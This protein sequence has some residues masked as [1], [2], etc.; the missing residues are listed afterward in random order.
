M[1][2]DVT[3]ESVHEVLEEV[4]KVRETG[5][6]ME[7]LDRE[8]RGRLAGLPYL[9]ETAGLTL[10][11][12]EIL[13]GF[14]IPPTYFDTYA[15]NFSA[16]TLA[17][18]QQAAVTYLAPGTLQIL[19]VGDAPVSLTK[20]QALAAMRPDLMASPVIQLDGEGNPVP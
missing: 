13:D 17:D 1:R 12:Y 4:R 2:A 19:V 16:V 3:A 15:R 10:T 14:G 9:F 18:A 11:Q 6:T 5:V 20:L 7:E 8:R